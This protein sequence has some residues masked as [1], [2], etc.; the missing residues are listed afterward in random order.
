M[1]RPSL[2]EVVV[3]VA[4]ENRQ[5]NKFQFRLNLPY[6]AIVLVCVKCKV[7]GAF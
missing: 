4:L 6:P 2:W 7:P 1:V 3:V 5:N